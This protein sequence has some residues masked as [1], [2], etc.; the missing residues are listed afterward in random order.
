MEDQMEKIKT[1]RRQSGRMG[2]ISKEQ[3]GV[4]K[5]DWEG[6]TWALFQ[7]DIAAHVDVVY[8]DVSS[9]RMIKKPLEHHLNHG[10]KHKDCYQNVQLLYFTGRFF[11]KWH[12]VLFGALGQDGTSLPPVRALVPFQSP[13]KRLLLLTVPQQDPQTPL[14]LPLKLIVEDQTEG[15]LLRPHLRAQQPRSL[16]LDVG[17]RIQVKVVPGKTWV[18]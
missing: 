14:R 11:W 6:L 12:L 3:S 7:L 18:E 2:R 9:G 17:A 13:E 16:A 1:K 5:E 8:S 15:P 10:P 4:G